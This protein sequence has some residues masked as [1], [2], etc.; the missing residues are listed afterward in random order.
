LSNDAPLLSDLQREPGLLT[1]G[2]SASRSKRE[3]QY[4]ERHSHG[5]HGGGTAAL[6]LSAAAGAS[7]A[8]SPVLGVGLLVLLFACLVGAVA[9]GVLAAAA[10]SASFLTYRVG[11]VFASIS[12]ADLVL[13]FALVA[14]AKPIVGAMRSKEL[15]LLLIV[16]M[17]YL[18]VMVVPVL[19]NPSSAAFVEYAHRAFLIAGSIMTGAACSRLC[20]EM[21]ALRI[22]LLVAVVFSVAAVFQALMSDG[23]PAYPLGVTKNHA[24]GLIAIAILLLLLLPTLIGRQL[25]FVS[26]AALFSG[27]AATQARAG[28]LAL[29][30]GVVY[31]CTFDSSSRRR[32]LFPLLVGGVLAAV[33]ISSLEAEQ[34]V[35]ADVALS[36]ATERLSFWEH[37]ATDWMRRP[38]IGNG[39]KYYVNPEFNFPVPYTS[40]FPDG[41]PPNPHNIVMQTLAE[42]GLLGLLALLLF[43]GGLIY[44]LRR[45]GGRFALPGQAVLLATAFMGVFDIFWLAGRTLVPF[46]IVGVAFYEAAKVDGGR[47]CQREVAVQS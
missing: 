3:H 45:V 19:A 15:R 16:A 31:V 30:L 46:F 12:L 2:S 39:L 23:G 47:D 37:A 27:L 41:G 43:V 8:F 38:F 13:F 17:A 32:L 9:P 28:I 26:L 40:E 24:G 6:L 34:D 20:R 25:R 42:S 44:A 10:L 36:S 35:P 22:F 33:S 29:A 5:W 4:A 21:L 1:G 11:P 7:S 14:L 18:G